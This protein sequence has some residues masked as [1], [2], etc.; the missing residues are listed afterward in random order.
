M[1]GVRNFFD[2]YLQVSNRLEQYTLLNQNFDKVELIIM[3]GTFPSFDV[4]YQDEFVK[5]ALKAMNDYGRFFDEGE[6]DFVKFKRFFELPVYV[7]DEART[8]RIQKKLLE[9]KGECELEKEQRKN[10]KS[11]VRCVAMCLETRPDYSKEKEINQ[12]LKLGCT[13]VELGVQSVYDNVLKKIERGHSVKDSVKATQLLKDSFLKTGYH[14]MSGL[15]GSSKE[16]DVEVFKELFSNPDFM[17]DALKIY[18]CMVIKGTKLSEDYEKGGFTPL[19]T[20]EAMEIIIKG[21]KHVPEFCRVM[22]VQ[23]D[24][25]SKIITSGV[26][27]TNFRQKLD[28]EMKKRGVKCRCI[29]CREPR[30]KTIDFDN[31]KMKRV[32]YSA[33]G[34]EEVFLSLDDVKND[35]L[36]GFLRLRIP[37]QPF[38]KEITPGSVG[39]RELHVYSPSVGIGKK[40]KGAVQHKGFGRKLMEEAEKI[41]SEEYDA[42]KILVISGIGVRE[43]Y[44]AKLGYRNDGPYV[45]KKI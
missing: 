18:P 13:R 26:D 29:R 23:R 19:T 39:I 33:S 14:I 22:R 32:D 31:V 1:R 12:M 6:I 38:R 37:Y 40:E 34:G 5:Y 36:L 17:P 7:K 44:R 41:A 35:L 8:K 4:S 28:E 11:S 30:G 45:S 16:M 3:G 27:I 43:Y 2:P 9:L 24:I 21:K 25:S 42:K 15:P 10:E 20:S